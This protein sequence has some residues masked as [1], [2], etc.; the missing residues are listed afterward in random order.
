MK[1]SSGKSRITHS[2]LG[3]ALSFCLLV[4][5]TVNATVVEFQTS[6]GNF[7]VNLT[8]QATPATVANF[9]TY[10]N[11]GDYIDSVVHRSVPG[12]VIQGGGFRVAAELP[13]LDIE[14]NDPVVNEPVF[15]N[16]RGTIAMAKLAS[17]PNSATN[18]W[19][20]NVADNTASLDGQNGGFTVFGQVVGDGMEVVDAIELLLTFNLGGV[21]SEIPLLDFTEDDAANGVPVDSANLVVIT[22]VV[23]SD[24]AEDTA[25]DLNLVENTAVDS[26]TAPDTGTP[27]TSEL[28]ENR[29]SSVGPALFLLL[30]S[31][32]VWRLRY[33]S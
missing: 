27:I 22:A 13:P 24:A 30:F 3:M 31:L 2:I 32:L 18:Q 5:L 29:A 15:S 23:I 33:R 17:D 9:L 19:F 4:P 7:E 11:D 26:T 21:F 16:L 25:A 28:L 8:D 20:I 1:K 12:F 10:V 14:A 6:L